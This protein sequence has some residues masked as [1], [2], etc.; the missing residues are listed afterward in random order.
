MRN[1][2]QIIIIQI[3][4]LINL[5]VSIVFC[6]SQ[7]CFITGIVLNKDTHR[8]IADANVF[9][10]YTLMGSS[11]DKFGRYAIDNVNPGQYFLVISHV[12]YND[13]YIHI[14]I[15]KDKN[16]KY[17]FELLPKIYQTKPII[18]YSDISEWK[19][20]LK[21]F[22]IEFLGTSNNS[23]MTSIT[24]TEV[25]EFN[26]LDGDTLFASAISPLKLFNRNLGY[27]IEYSL[28]HFES[29]YDYVKFT[30]FPKFTELESVEPKIIN[31]WNVSRRNTYKGSLRHFLKV[32]C[33]NYDFTSGNTDSIDFE[34]DHSDI[35]SEGYKQ[36][37]K[38]DNFVTRNG[39]E[40][41]HKSTLRSHMDIKPII[42]LV[43]TNNYLKPTDIESE[44][45]F[46]FNNFLE[47]RYT[48]PN[49]TGFFL[50]SEDDISWITLEK[51]SIIIDKSGRYYETFSIKTSGF[52]GLERISDILPFEYVYEDSLLHFND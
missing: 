49:Q 4:L 34:I 40:V 37:Y 24:N 36:E 29:T 31:T 43:N 19:K 25:L 17:N 26:N 46:K 23:K 27:K 42:K 8:P 10:A 11:T 50:K 9:L 20:K 1:K 16:Y 21:R 52:W 30:G 5:Y 13:I 39:F 51:D 28:Y 35:T 47:I 14:N 32:I 44:M 18:V 2:F 15:K 48:D 33:L 38:A 41:L 22:L 6:R 7:D 45:Y 3:F 12:G